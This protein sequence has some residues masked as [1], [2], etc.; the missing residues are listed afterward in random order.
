MKVDAHQ[1]HLK[2]LQDR[3]RVM[4][5]QNLKRLQSNAQQTKEHYVKLIEESKPSKHTVDVRA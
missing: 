1:R 5:E 4:H 2:E 3:S